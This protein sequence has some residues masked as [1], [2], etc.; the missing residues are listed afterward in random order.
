MIVLMANVLKGSSL[1]GATQHG[2]ARAEAFQRSCTW[3]TIARQS[4]WGAY[5]A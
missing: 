3:Q 2:A 1:I 5:V 4:M